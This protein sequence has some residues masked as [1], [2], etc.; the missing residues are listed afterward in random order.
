[1]EK[2]KLVEIFVS[3]A[4]NQESIGKYKNAERLYLLSGNTDSAIAMYK[5]L[6]LYDQASESITIRIIYCLVN[7]SKV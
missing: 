5:K 1:M 4:K 7:I 6:R 3:E 2:D